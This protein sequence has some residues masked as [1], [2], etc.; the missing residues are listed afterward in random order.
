MAGLNIMV[1]AIKSPSGTYYMSHTGFRNNRQIEF[2][3]NNHRAARWT[4]EK[5][6]TKAMWQ[7]DLTDCEVVE[8]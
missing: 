3:T 2:T 7:L 6:A 8:L 1:Y 4:E 5:S